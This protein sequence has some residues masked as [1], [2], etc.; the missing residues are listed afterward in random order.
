MSDIIYARETSL[1]VEEFYDVLVESGLAERRPVDDKARL[2]KMCSNAN[3]IMTAR[4]N[5]KLVG[6]VRA[7]SDFSYCTYFSDLA[8]VKS[9]Q[10]SGLGKSLIHHLRLAVPEATLIL[11]SA[12]AATRYYPRIGMHPHQ[13]AFT[14]VPGEPLI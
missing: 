1:N 6:V 4:K 3:L 9:M 7:L 14:I 8:V 13:H 10:K 12:P 11:L 5:S 2:E